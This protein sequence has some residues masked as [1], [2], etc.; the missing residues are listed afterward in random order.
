M[1]DT[2][3][4]IVVQGSIPELCGCIETSMVE[5]FD[6]RYVALYEVAIAAATATAYVV[7]VLGDRASSISTLIVRSP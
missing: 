5:L 4:A 1:I 7:G 6:N 3:V 2:K